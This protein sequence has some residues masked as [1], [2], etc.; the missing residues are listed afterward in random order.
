MTQNLGGLFLFQ[1]H[2]YHRVE[3]RARLLSR[4]GLVNEL[5]RVLP[6]PHELDE[7]KEEAGG[8]GLIGSAEC[9]GHGATARCESPLSWASPRSRAFPRA[10]RASFSKCKGNKQFWLDKPQVKVPGSQPDGK[11]RIGP[12]FLFLVQFFGFPWR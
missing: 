12:F 11:E 2:S 7:Q 4:A 9:D 10:I 5:K 6:W 3:L 8:G 1:G